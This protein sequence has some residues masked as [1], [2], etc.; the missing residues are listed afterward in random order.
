MFCWV[1]LRS[2]K[3]IETCL[4]APL[5][6]MK[7]IESSAKTETKQSVK[8]PGS[9]VKLINSSFKDSTDKFV[10]RQG[11]M[12]ASEIGL[13]AFTVIDT[14][15]QRRHGNWANMI[16]TR[17][18]A[19]V[20]LPSDAKLENVAHRIEWKCDKMILGPAQDIWLHP[21]FALRY[22]W[23]N[24]NNG[25][26]LLQRVPV[27]LLTES[28]CC[29]IA[30]ANPYYVCYLPDKVWT[31]TMV[32]VLLEQ[33]ITNLRHVPV[34][35]WS[36]EMVDRLFIKDTDSYFWIPKEFRTPA[37]TASFER[38]AKRRIRGGP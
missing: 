3:L 31:Q 20:T 11:L 35:F 32:D 4:Y 10:Y 37:M 24:I 21:D 16:D 28:L 6:K 12:V 15:I 5:Y 2:L 22:H 38:Y 25:P 19:P 14:E 36:Q 30:R 23:N 34:R 29:K 7:T 13:D 9:L 33:D 27:T 8:V 18:F 17:Y 1:S 26:N